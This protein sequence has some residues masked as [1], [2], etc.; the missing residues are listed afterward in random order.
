MKTYMD[1]LPEPKIERQELHCHNCNGYVQFDI[2]IHLNGNHVIICPNCKHEHLRVVKNGII[3]DERWG[4][5]NINT[6]MYT[7]TGTTYTTASYS[8]TATATTSVDMYLSSSWL[9]STGG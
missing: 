6:Q 2:D 7:A 9:N 4:S 1:K 8:A 3:T 5:R